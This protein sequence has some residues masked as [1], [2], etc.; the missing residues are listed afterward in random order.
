MI[1]FKVL[2]VR[3]TPK[4]YHLHLPAWH[5]R[6]PASKT[7]RFYAQKQRKQFPFILLLLLFDI[8]TLSK[9]PID[10]EDQSRF[11]YPPPPIGNITSMLSLV[12]PFIK[13]TIV[14]A[15]LWANQTNYNE[16]QYLGYELELK[17][18][19]PWKINLIRFFKPY[20]SL[21]NEKVIYKSTYHLHMHIR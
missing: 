13:I 5:S 1:I 21:Y 2:G 19:F 8:H 12:N 10:R 7:L 14:A 17:S 4:L 9:V 16:R 11:S 20:R 6:K 15:K 3:C 18:T